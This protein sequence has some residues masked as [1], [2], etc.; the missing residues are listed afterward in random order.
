MPVRHPQQ[1]FTLIEVMIAFF[2][3]AVG[4]LGMA[5][6]LTNSVRS[7]QS[8][9]YRTQAAYLAEDMADRIRANRSTADYTVVTA[10]NNNCVITSASA[11]KSSNNCT[12][13]NMAA[14]DV[15]DWEQTVARMLPGDPVGLT[16]LDA[17]SVVCLDSTPQDGTD[18][19]AA[20]DGCDD[21]PLSAGGLIAIKVW[22]DD[23]RDGDIDANDP[24]VVVSLR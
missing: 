5:A 23:D 4:L 1:G 13:A 2:I 19:T 7:S 20:N 16:L 17:M 18:G 8:A 22:W 9:Y 24:R 6:L 3:L 11:T 15:Y 10:T 14:W 12:S 21:T